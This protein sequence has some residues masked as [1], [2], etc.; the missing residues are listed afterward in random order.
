MCQR[1]KMEIVQEAT[2]SVGQSSL[3][4]IHQ[5]DRHPLA[6]LGGP[7]VE[8]RDACYLHRLRQHR[9]RVGLQCLIDFRKA[10]NY[11]QC[12]ARLNVGAKLSSSDLAHYPIVHAEQDRIFRPV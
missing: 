7:S 5:P 4:I 8:S 6:N 10:A 11:D 1:A 2:D 9:F 3:R 12:A